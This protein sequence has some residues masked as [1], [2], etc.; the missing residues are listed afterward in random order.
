MNDQQ[1]FRDTIYLI[2]AKSKPGQLFSYGELA[3]Q[4]GQPRAARYVARILKQLPKD[5]TL[6]WHRVVNSR[7]CISL[8]LDQPSGQNQQALLEA[9]GWTIINGKLI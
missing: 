1:Q 4:A 8:P 2:L 3:A 9:E 7:R 5:S 6:P